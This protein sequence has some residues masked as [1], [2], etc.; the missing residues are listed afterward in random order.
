MTETERADI[1]DI[2]IRRA[3]AS[4]VEA[5]ADLASRTFGDE[6]GASLQ[7]EE[8]ALELETRRSPAYFAEALKSATVLVAERNRAL[9]GYVQFGRVD[10]PELSAAAGDRQL[11]RLYVDR[12]AQGRGLGRQLLAAAL[13]HPDMASAR[14]IFLTVWEENTRALRLYESVGFRRAGVTAYSIGD[15]PIGEDLVMCL[16]RPPREG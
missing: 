11:H 12:A 13:A 6:F 4:D 7:P 14:R 5:L 15:E 2:E 3:H 10:I 9:V 1:G 16:S 8:L